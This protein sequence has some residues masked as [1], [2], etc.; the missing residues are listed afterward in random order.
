VTTHL[1]SGA[2]I[3]RR[4]APVLDRPSL[5]K[6]RVTKST[7]LFIVGVI[8]RSGRLT[9]RSGASPLTKMTQGCGNV[10]EGGTAPVRERAGTKSRRRS[11]SGRRR[12]EGQHEVYGMIVRN[13][14]SHDVRF[15]NRLRR[16]L[17]TGIVLAAGFG[18]LAGT[19]HAAA[20]VPDIVAEDMAQRSPDI[21]WPTE[22]SPASADMFS[23]NE[24]TITAACPVAWHHL[25]AATA[26]PSWYPNSQNVRLLNSSDGNLQDHTHFTWETFGVPIDSTI[27]EYVPGSRLAW[28]GDGPGIRAYHTWLL[29]P[30]A[31]GCRIITEEATK[32]PAAIKGR[33]SKP[34]A[35]HAGH[36]QWLVRM[37]QLSER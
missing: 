29:S 3:D 26:W 33:Q 9:S 31:G 32:G 24:I 14:A 10:L 17:L 18:L 37:K 19:A 8:V 25:V 4:R 23:H 34:G 2:L 22:L 16:G 30:V 11:R 1:A 6:R 5:P 13:S 21:H 28:F 27:Y 36:E 7:K 15:S 35:L 20:G 12:F